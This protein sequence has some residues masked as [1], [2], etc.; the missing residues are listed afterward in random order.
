MRLLIVEDEPLARER[1]EQL[2]HQ[3]RPDATIVGALESVEE[4]VEW[5][6]EHPAP[7]LAFFDIQLA[8]GLSFSI[9]EQVSIR[10]PV[11]FTTAFDQ[12]ALQSFEVNSIDY[13]LKPIDAADLQRAFRKYEELTQTREATA[14]DLAVLQQLMKGAQTNYR[15][16]YMVQ[17]GPYL[18]PLRT[19]A[20]LYIFSENRL[21]WVR[22][23]DGRKYALD[24]TM[25][26]LAAELDPRVF[27]R[28][29]RQYIVAQKAVVRLVPYSNSR[30]RVEL[31]HVPNDTQIIVSRERVRA[32]RNW[33]GGN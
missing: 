10:F 21:S 18:V 23:E 13:L 1:L 33:L 8:D 7:T 29:S 6:S 19:A 31:P 26:Q 5:L 27:F 2:I 30:L 15:D 3:Q 28:I 12:Y 24:R 16:R 14:I 17:S 11:V 9:F 25:D 20:F 4:A 22:T 32:F